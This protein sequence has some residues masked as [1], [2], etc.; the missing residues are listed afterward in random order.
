MV[1]LILILRE[2]L[3]LKIH[4]QDL[5]FNGEIKPIEEKCPVCGAEL[6]KYNW[7]D[8]KLQKRR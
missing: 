8:R 1:I 2:K 3:Y 4:V 7:D 6:V 5:F